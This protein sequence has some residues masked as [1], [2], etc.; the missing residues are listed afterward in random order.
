MIEITNLQ[1]CYGSVAAVSDVSFQVPAGT[2]TGFVGPNGSGKSTTMRC[3][4]GLTLPTSGETRVLGQ[5]YIDIPNPA[6]RVGVL[7][8][9]N[10][11]HRGRTGVETLRLSA[12]IMGIPLTRVDEVMALVGLSRKEGRRRVGQYSL[13]MKQR[14]GIAQAL[15]GNPE[16]LILDE[17]VNGLDPQ[18]IHWMRGLLRSYADAGGAVLLSSHLLHEV[19]QIADDVVMIGHGRVIAQGPISEFI[20]SGHSLEDYYLGLTVDA[21]RT[22]EATPQNPAT[23]EALAASAQATA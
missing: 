2:I 9:A 1:K 15:L 6:S 5:R 7:L 18:G 10:S 13:G 4:V 8:D 16:A 19:Q 11:F 23:L 14:L 12:T 20:S 3:L 22:H 17:P 21:A